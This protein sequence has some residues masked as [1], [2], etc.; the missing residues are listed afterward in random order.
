MSRPM[1]LQEFCN[2]SPPK[3]LADFVDGVLAA[4]RD[5]K[6]PKSCGHPF[7]LAYLTFFPH[8]VEELIDAETKRR[9]S[10]N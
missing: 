8:S 6:L 1:T 5:G 7:V 2:L 9:S 3:E 4:A 10:S